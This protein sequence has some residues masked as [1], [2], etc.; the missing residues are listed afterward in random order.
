MIA[1]THLGKNLQIT[2]SQLV[3]TPDNTLAGM[4]LNRQ[5]KD[6]SSQLPVIPFDT[7]VLEDARITYPLPALGAVA[8][9]ING[10]ASRE[11]A[12]MKAVMDTTLIAAEQTEATLRLTGTL[13]QNGH[14][15]G[16]ADILDARGET[17]DV[18]LRRVTGWIAAEGTLIDLS[19]TAAD[20]QITIGSIKAFGLPVR[21]ANLTLSHKAEASTLALNAD[22]MS[23][24]GTI[25]VDATRKDGDIRLQT[26]VH[27]KKLSALGSK[28]LKGTA[29][30]S[31][32]IN[33]KDNG[34][35]LD[36][37]GKVTAKSLSLP[38]LVDNAEISG[39]LDIKTNDAN[40]DITASLALDKLTTGKKP[41]PVVPFKIKATARPGQ[42]AATFNGEI[43]EP[44]GAFFLTF[45]GKHNTGT[46]AGD[47]RL[48]MP[49]VTF[50][51][52]VNEL[53]DII[54]MSA[55]WVRDTAGEAGFSM[56]A[57]WKKGKRPDV[58]GTVLL[59]NFSGATN[60]FVFQGLSTVL[61]LNSLSPPAF[62][63]Q[64]VSIGLFNPGVPLTNGR[65]EA[66]LTPKG[67]MTLHN[68]EW[69]LAKGTLSAENITFPNV[70]KLNS[71]IKIIAK[72]INLEELFK[73]IPMNGLD[74]TGTAGG[75][76]P[77][78]VREDSISVNDGVLETEGSGFIRYNPQD[79]PAFLRD[80]S[81]RQIADLRV[82]LQAF[83]Y[84]TLKL[85][86]NGELG[87]DQKVT[88]N[89]K[90]KNPLF[91][92]GHPVNLNFNVEGPLQNILK[93][94]PGGSQ[95]P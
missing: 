88:L 44:N 61:K 16:Q 58:S 26:E 2:G 92:D 54:P 62:E 95:I 37:K 10:R 71:D 35:Q 34:K 1:V 24:G 20:G 69:T 8:A 21:G 79:V 41:P 5:S 43:T 55:A 53:K 72:S 73:M 18:N 94:K 67:A 17:K 11:G 22:V 57:R 12:A 86:L 85:G 89:I 93:Y 19:H 77:I 46:S 39:A 4:P 23:D 32:L 48:D 87:K 9:T 63:K 66:S 25:F 74:A 52:G 50:I 80:T 6:T 81:N 70:K 3:I 60:D 78:S 33:I 13:E 14:F 49:P 36:G 64:A 84:D 65:V 31:L 30:A 38:G 51:K 75:V 40:G 7:I 82:A 29:D 76:L 42:D 47:L 91:Y 56:A 27:L 68:M 28:D 83:A 90:G 15:Q 45:K 59:K